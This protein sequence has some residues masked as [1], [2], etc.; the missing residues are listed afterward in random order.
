MNQTAL[1]IAGLA[2]AAAAALAAAP[3]EARQRAARCVVE[4]PQTVP[5]RGP[6]LFEAERG[7]SFTIDPPRGRLFVGDVTTISVA[8]TGRGVAE[9]RGLV[10]GINSRWG[11]AIRSS[12]DA[13][14]WIGSDFRVCAY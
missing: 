8:V 6:C 14:C 12:R 3:A 10:G 5:Y 7:G 13:A 4:A 11:R 9:V 1:L 2:S